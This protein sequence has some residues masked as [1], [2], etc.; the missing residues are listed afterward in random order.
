MQ[1]KQVSV[2]KRSF[3]NANLGTFIYINKLSDN[4]F[5]FSSKID[6]ILLIIN[7]LYFCSFWMRHS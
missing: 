4:Y 7:M 5:Y 2:K 1:T 3:N 6:Y